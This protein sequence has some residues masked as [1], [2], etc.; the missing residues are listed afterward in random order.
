VPAGKLSVLEGQAYPF[1]AP[2]LPQSNP[3]RILEPI[4][5]S[6]IVAGLVFLFISNTE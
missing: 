6:A 5:V 1:T 3:G 4:I 2:T